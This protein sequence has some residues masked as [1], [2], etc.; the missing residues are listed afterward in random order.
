MGGFS[1]PGPGDAL[2]LKEDCRDAYRTL[3]PSRLPF[4]ATVYNSAFTALI[5]PLLPLWS[6]E[7]LEYTDC[8]RLPKEGIPSIRTSPSIQGWLPAAGVTYAPVNNP[9]SHSER[10]AL[11][12]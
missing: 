9:H 7:G 3:C 5:I 1:G 6:Q 8:G 10:S 4:P 12:S 2:S 11:A